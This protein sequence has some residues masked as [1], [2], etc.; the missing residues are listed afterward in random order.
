MALK[1]L[2][3]LIDDKLADVFHAKKADPVTLRAP[4]LRALE[5]TRDQFLATEPARGPKWIRISNGVVAFT[6]TLRGGHPLPINGQTT[7]Y[8]PSERF[9]EFL[10]RMTEAV[11]AGEFD[12]ELEN[13]GNG[14]GQTAK[15]KVPTTRKP[16]DPNAPRKAG[17]SDERRAKFAAT[18]AARNVAKS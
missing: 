4:V 16:R 12:A 1:D 5:R 7:V 10:D 3:G 15:V 11:E 18:V 2:F 17:W 9:I 14:A 13:P 6:P 8:V